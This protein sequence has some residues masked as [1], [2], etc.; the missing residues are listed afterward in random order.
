MDGSFAHPNVSFAGYQTPRKQPRE[1][2][3][4]DYIA[5]AQLGQSPGGRAATY[6]SRAA[7]QREL[8][9]TRNALRGQERSSDDMRRQVGR[10]LTCL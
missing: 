8:D 5:A 9:G 4:A 2:E 6:E 7:I 10:T 3:S 1:S